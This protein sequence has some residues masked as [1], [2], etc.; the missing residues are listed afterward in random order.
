VISVACDDEG[1]T[2]RVVR[3]ETQEVKVAGEW[4][5]RFA[6]EERVERRSES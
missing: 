4:C 2:G 6:W 5:S 1:Q 3:S